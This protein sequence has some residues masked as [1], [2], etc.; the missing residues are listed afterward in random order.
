[1]NR[2]AVDSK[3]Y[4]GKTTLDGDVVKGKTN[5]I[6]DVKLVAELLVENGIETVPDICLEQGLWHDD[7]EKSIGEFIPKATWI[8]K[9]G[10]NLKKLTAKRKSQGFLKEMKYDMSTQK[11]TPGETREEYDNKLGKINEGMGIKE[12]DDYDI[13]LRIAN[14][15]ATDPKYFEELTKDISAKLTNIAANR[16]DGDVVLSPV[17]EDRMKRFHKFLVAAG[18]YEGNMR[19]SDGA[20]SPERA[21]RW[22]VEW[23]IE[24]PEAKSEYKEAV[25]AN[26][27]KMYND[28]KFRDGVYVK[29][30]DGNYWAKSEHFY[31]YNGSDPKYKTKEDYAAALLMEDMG[32]KKVFEDQE[33][34]HKMK[35]ELKTGIYW[36]DVVKYVKEYTTYKREED[37]SMFRSSSSAAA[38]EG[39]FDDKRRMPNKSGTSPSITNHK[40]GEAIDIN[41]K[42]FI[43]K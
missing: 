32:I 1:M 27:I 42:N 12:G 7:L 33:D 41:S 21:H 40:T 38:S 6:E 39:Y 31:Y 15:A 24:S 37:Q 19:I 13:V 18:L 29:D 22:C 14:K 26:L 10:N 9:N 16:K 28:K 25:K 11:H 35:G 3:I 34:K 36:D 30:I 2:N 8:G 4:V 43:L 20:R 17:L 23:V 5:N